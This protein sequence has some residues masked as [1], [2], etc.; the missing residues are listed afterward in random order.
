MRQVHKEELTETGYVYVYPHPERYVKTHK[1]TFQFFGFEKIIRKLDKYLK[2]NNEGL[3]EESPHEADF[4]DSDEEKSPQQ[5]EFER[6]LEECQE[7]L[8]GNNPGSAKNHS[9]FGLR[10]NRKSF[11]ELTTLASDE[12]KFNEGD[13]NKNSP[14]IKKQ[15]L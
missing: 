3:E 10:E 15:S 7:L 14:S 4:S 8:G 1:N 6:Y 12:E 11:F 13:F 5:K 2:G 9:G